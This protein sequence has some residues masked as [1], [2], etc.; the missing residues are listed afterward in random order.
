MLFIFYYTTVRRIFGNPKIEFINACKLLIINS[1]FFNRLR[2]YM[3]SQFQFKSCKK[4]FIAKYSY[5]GN[6]RSVSRFSLDSS[7]TKL[8][9]NLIMQRLS[10]EKF[11]NTLKRPVP[12]HNYAQVDWTER[13]GRLDEAKR[14]FA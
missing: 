4:Y 1:A 11:Q 5:S 7:G 9:N 12:L 10:A 3:I 6:Y 8:Q 14:H 2:Y 13:A